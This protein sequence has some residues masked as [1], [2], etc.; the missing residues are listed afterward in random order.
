MS[1]NNEKLLRGGKGG[2][3][4][5]LKA[6]QKIKKKKKERPDLREQKLLLGTLRFYNDK[7]FW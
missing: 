6:V 4:G 3:Q 7:G 5:L 2:T 1:K